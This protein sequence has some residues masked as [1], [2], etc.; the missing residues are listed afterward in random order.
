MWSADR[1]LCLIFNGEIYNYI[2]LRAELEAMGHQFSSTSDTEVLLE[3]YR[4]WGPEA[5]KRFRGMFAFAIVD[6]RSDTVVLARDPYGKK[7]LFL[8]QKGCDIFFGSE[9]EPITTMPGFTRS[10]DWD[11][12]DALRAKMPVSTW[13]VEEMRR[14]DLL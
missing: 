1:T 12:L 11:A 13:T 5:V 14:H 2:E 7:P 6:T 10:F 9:I 3:A 4:A 8:A